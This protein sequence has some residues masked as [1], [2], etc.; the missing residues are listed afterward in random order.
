MIPESTFPI[1]PMSQHIPA[2]GERGSL[3]SARFWSGQ[4]IDCFRLRAVAESDVR[5]LSLVLRNKSWQ[6]HLRNGISDGPA[7]L[8]SV[9]AWGFIDWILVEDAWESSREITS[10]PVN[11]LFAGFFDSIWGAVSALQ[12]SANITRPIL[13]SVRA[14]LTWHIDTVSEKNSPAN[15]KSYLSSKDS[16][17]L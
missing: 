6:N 8:V 5:Q 1:S 10:R 13:W 2:A 4:D 3:A 17:Q 15:S 9:K 14:S 12:V 7:G 16:L 11:T